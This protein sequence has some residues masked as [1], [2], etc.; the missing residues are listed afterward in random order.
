ML[1]TSK[2]KLNEQFWLICEDDLWNQPL[3]IVYSSLPSLLQTDCSFSDA[4]T[5]LEYHYHHRHHLFAQRKQY[6]CKLSR[7]KRHECTN[8][9]VKQR[10]VMT[11]RKLS[12]YIPSLR[13]HLTTRSL[14]TAPAL[15]SSTL[16][17]E[18]QTYINLWS[19]EPSCPQKSS[20]CD[21]IFCE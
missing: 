19:T 21:S 1:C 3:N 13:L 14:G 20:I 17:L 2:W 6:K 11:K 5:L 16:L 7:T 12:A 8:I 9:I 4:P 18:C 15:L 10:H